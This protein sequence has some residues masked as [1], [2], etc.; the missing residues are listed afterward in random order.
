MLTKAMEQA[1]ATTEGLAELART[2]LW[3]AL[4]GVES[5]AAVAECLRTRLVEGRILGETYWQGGMDCPLGTI[6][7]FD[8]ADDPAAEASARPTGS[9]YALEDWAAPI[10]P[11]DVPDLLANEDTGA[12]RAAS[13][14]QW[15]DE[16][17]A[18]RVSD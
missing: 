10:Q 15:I 6:A 16:F 18:E 9:T 17:E 11:G 4:D 2:Q 12:F 8:G 5:S 13:L 14:M 7:Y 1:V 3:L